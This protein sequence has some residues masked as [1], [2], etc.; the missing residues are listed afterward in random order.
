MNLPRLR[1]IEWV[2]VMDFLK[3]TIAELASTPERVEELVRGL[4]A[5]QQAWKPSAETFSVRENVWHLRDIDVEGYEHRVRKILSQE[6]PVLPD[7]DGG[8]LARERNY[9]G[10][11]AEVALEDLRKS[12]AASMERLRAC[13]A[14]DLA[15]EAEMQGLGVIDLRRLL[16]LWLRHD[17]DHLA[18]LAQLRRAIESGDAPTFVQHQAA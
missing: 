11:P 12:R 2:W 18:D 16:E 15:R 7:V 13:S 5:S 9:N 10:Q 6:C 17:R 3:E 8:K 1:R 4:T 14:A